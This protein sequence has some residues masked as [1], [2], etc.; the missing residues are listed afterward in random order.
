VRES[1]S[2]L[3]AIRHYYLGD[4]KQ[5]KAAAAAV[6]GQMNITQTETEQNMHILAYSARPYDESYLQCSNKNIL[7]A[8]KVMKMA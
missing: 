8:S 5:L 3:N 6:A 7:S 2:K 1:C 4:Q